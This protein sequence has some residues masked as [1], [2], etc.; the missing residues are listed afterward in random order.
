MN[1]SSNL[2]VKPP[3]LRMPTTTTTTTKSNP[4]AMFVHAITSHEVAPSWLP[5]SPQPPL[6][7]STS[8]PRTQANHVAAPPS[9]HHRAQT[10]KSL[11]SGALFAPHRNRGSVS[12]REPCLRPLHIA[13][14]TERVAGHLTPPLTI[15]R[16]FIVAR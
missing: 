13:T 11:G 10:Q 15:T 9:D 7:P 6:H 2:H 4:T 16:L 12:H 1:Y 14:C 8:P 3:S 5:H